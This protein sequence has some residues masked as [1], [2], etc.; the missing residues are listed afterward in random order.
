MGLLYF[1]NFSGRL[2]CRVGKP[3]GDNNKE[4]KVGSTKKCDLG[5]KHK[6]K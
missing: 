4:K 3:R 5:T 1:K 2:A 6:K